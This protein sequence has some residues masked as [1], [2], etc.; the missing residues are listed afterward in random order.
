MTELLNKNVYVVDDFLYNPDETVAYAKSLDMDGVRGGGHFLRTK[1]V[2]NWAMVPAL[3]AIIKRKIIIDNQWDEDNPNNMNMSY[4]TT[5]PDVTQNHIHHDWFDW[6]G[7]LYLSKEVPPEWGT[8]FWK[9]KESG[10]EFAFGKKTIDGWAPEPDL[11]ADVGVADFE[12]TD[13]VEYK[14]NRLVLFRGTMFHSAT[15]PDNAEPYKRFNQFLYFN[16]EDY[17][18]WRNGVASHTLEIKK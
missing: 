14:Y 17:P 15:F 12:Q 1:P 3:E 8:A 4:Y 10:D 2:I 16:V 18:G 11:R 6:S 5:F 9:H 13:V 7:V